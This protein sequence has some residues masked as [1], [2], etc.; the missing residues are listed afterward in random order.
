MQQFC[1][2]FF[3]WYG[4]CTS[5]I[6]FSSVQFSSVTQSCPTLWDPI[7]CSLPGS[8]VHGD[9]PGKN[10]GVGCHALFQ[11]IFPTKRLNPGL[12]HCR[13]IVYHLSHQ[14]SWRRQWQPTPV[15]FHGKSHGQ[16][17][18]EGYSPWGHKESDKMECTCTP[19][20]Y[21]MLD[22]IKIPSL[23]EIL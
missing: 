12:P 18:L 5:L 21:E 16:R 15:L 11:G 19:T 10:T 3:N 6:L 2:V 4:D 17:S 7:D 22:D 13:W 20:V 8:S 1:F 14:G 9:S 23:T